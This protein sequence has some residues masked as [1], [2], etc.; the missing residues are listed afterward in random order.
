MIM[1]LITKAIK[2]FSASSRQKR[3]K[4]FRDSFYLCANTR[5]LDLGSGNGSHINSVLQGTGV[6]PKNVFM[7][8][9][10]SSSLKK[11]HRLYGYNRVVVEESRPL[12][13]SDYFFD[14]V[15]CSSVI[16]HVTVP[17]NEV[18]D[19]FSTTE[20]KNLSFKKQQQFAREIMR[21]GK[22]Y[23]VQTPN[24]YFPIESQW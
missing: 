24:R 11:G 17:K 10:S 2:R 3:A 18:W 6:D 4:I 8:D 19:H 14:I 21:V 12:P 23:F 5:V 13:F 22:Q 7:A 16:E 20:F 1:G 9:I 15:F